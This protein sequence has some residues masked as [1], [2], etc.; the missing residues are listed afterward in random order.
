V[1]F[2]DSDN[3]PDL[4][5][6][7]ADG[8]VA[9]HLNIGTTGA[10]VFDEGQ[11][12][13]AGGVGLDV[14]SRAT[15]VFVDWNDDDR[16]DLVVGGYDGLIHVFINTGAD[17]APVFAAET[18]AQT[19]AGTLQVSSNRASPVLLDFNGSGLPDLIVGNT[20]GQLVA[21]INVGSAGS[22]VFGYFTLIT[23]QASTIDLAGSARSRPAACDWD[24]DGEIDLLVGGSDGRVHL[25]RGY[26]GNVVGVQAPVL[27]AHLKAPWPNPFNPVVNL[28][29]D[30][31]AP[32][33][34]VLAIHDAA[35]REVIRL[36]DGEWPSGRHAVRWD[37]R[38]AGGRV[39]PSGAY[40]ARLVTSRGQETRKLLLVR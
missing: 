40:F 18:L 2:W 25:Y 34:A 36:V 6:G 5:I 38:D 7:L 24:A 1:A 28:A 23:S 30:F 27:V 10:P 16:R 22:P 26:A 14:G 3:L 29:C 31:E 39:Q 21:Y 4:I 19:T 35:G 32:T 8:R 15:P 37:G 11:Y 12:L 13:Q 20:N 33:R 17:T 9:I